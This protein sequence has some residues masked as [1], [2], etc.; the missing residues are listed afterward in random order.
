M[1]STIEHSIR[2]KTRKSILI[3]ILLIIFIATIITFSILYSIPIGMNL[4]RNYQ[5]TTCI[6]KSIKIQNETNIYD[7]NI[8]N[9]NNIY[10]I[11]NIDNIDNIDN[12]NDDNIK[13][14]KRKINNIKSR[15]Q[16]FVLFNYNGEQIIEATFNTINQSYILDNPNE[17]L[18]ANG[19]IINAVKDCMYN[20]DNGKNIYL[21]SV[22]SKELFI[23]LNHIITAMFIMYIS[24]ISFFILFMT[25]WNNSCCCCILSN[26]ERGVKKIKNKNQFLLNSTEN[27]KLI[28]DN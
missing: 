9:I 11:N 10:N 8:N 18:L 5:S 16:I 3:V 1:K 17:W 15:I 20:K 6:I 4:I 19:I 12:N 28:Q 21:I 26:D 25:I 24:F 27:N 23:N 2:E 7:N 13:K 14:R 22:V